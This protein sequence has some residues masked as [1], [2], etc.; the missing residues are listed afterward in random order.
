MATPVARKTRKALFICLECDRKFYSTR[1][2]QKAAWNGCP[3][4]G[5]SDIEASYLQA[6]CARVQLGQTQDW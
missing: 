1:A 3:G 2:A 5:G 4:C 6:G